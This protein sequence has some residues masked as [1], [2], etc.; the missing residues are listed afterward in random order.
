MLMWF[1]GRGYF[2]HE[3]EEI[4]G[5]YDHYEIRRITLYL[6]SSSS[7]VVS[8]V[9]FRMIQEV[10]TVKKLVHTWR[11][12]NGVTHFLS[13][14]PGAHHYSISFPDQRRYGGDFE[15]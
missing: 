8:S 9:G 14:G 12:D 13:R 7:F 11:F 4:V 15:L 1:V 2:R 10:F 6:I 5:I 3:L